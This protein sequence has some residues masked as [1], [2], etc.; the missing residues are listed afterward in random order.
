MLGSVVPEPC[1]VVL[2]DGRTLCLR[3]VTPADASAILALYAR[4]SSNSLYNRFG[5]PH[6]PEL[7]ET[8]ALCHI[9]PQ[10]GF[11]L[12]AEHGPRL[13]GVAHYV[14]TSPG[15]A[16]VAFVVDDD[17]HGLGVATSL[18]E[19]LAEI[20][21][22]QHLE[23]FEAYVLRGNTDMLRVF[24]D[25]GFEVRTDD[26]HEYEH[27]TLALSPT[28]R[29][30]D[31]TA[32]RAET[33]AS[34]S[35]RPFFEPGSVAVVGASRR[36]GQIGSEIFH[37][38]A[39]GG[40]TGR[41]VPVNPQAGEI[42]SVPCY[43]RV[44][45]IPG[46]I[47]LAVVAVPAAAVEAVVD[48]CIAKGVRAIVVISAG[49]GEIGGEGRAR[50]AAL[51]EK[52]RNAGIRM[53]GPNC[54]G[55]LNTDPA[56]HLNATFSPVF[57][58]SG[59]IAFSS[60]SG[61]L[62]LAILDFAARLNL[63]VSS[64]VSVGN[65]ADVSSNDLLQYW[66]EDPRTSVILLYLE[67][68][69]NPRTFSRLARRIGR[70]KPIVA[71]KAGRSLSGARAASSHTGALAAS[72]VV[73]DALF[74]EAGVIRTTTLEELFDVAVLLANQPV[75]RGNRVAILTNAGGPGILAAD[76][77]EALNMTVPRLAPSTVAALRAFLPAAA[78]IGNPVDMLATASAD[79]Y[80]RAIPLLLADPDVD[81]LLTIFIPPLVT[82]PEDVAK[83]IVDSVRRSDKPVITTFL[84]AQ[85]A[86]ASLDPVPCYAFPESAL[87]ALAH[88]ATY[89]K[90]RS[91]PAGSTRTFVDARRDTARDIVDR[92]VA[93]G[94]GWLSP[95]DGV[96]LLS[97]FNIPA[98]PTF[99]AAT[100]NEAVVM[101]TVAGYPCVMKAVGPGILH[102]SE[103]HA[104]VLDIADEA[105]ARAA[106]IDLSS[107]LGDAMTGVVVQPMVQD[108][109]EMFVGVT[110]DATFG[111]VIV[112][113]TGG[114]LVELL[115]DSVCR[116]HPLT[117]E[118]A[119]E[120][121]DTV[122][123]IVLLRGFRGSP[124]CKEEALHD[125]LLRV[126]ALVDC[127][128]E[129]VELDLNPVMVTPSGAQVADARIRVER[130][131]VPAPSRRIRY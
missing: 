26:A 24:K 38:L 114:T 52:V 61:A 60:Q 86:P 125:M 35:M 96:A 66:S 53:I 70:R 91:A 50:E 11:A 106:Y 44:S 57:P 127:C 46:E 71:V 88:A 20:A 48:D 94:G 120:M 119:R 76:A 5:A 63:G 41:V 93:S 110:L 6:R 83:A 13:V 74:R 99:S 39:A 42:A 34:A 1:D 77:A 10:D 40:F 23:T 116:L 72:D 47:D 18:L 98:A 87:R 128:P 102:K 31:R 129:I 78:S 103:L 28:D 68:F 126:S 19:R 113:G 130:G 32:A 100:P 59:R 84:G 22:R 105:A 27:V 17:M 45:A 80:R 82:D 3:A 107:R 30:L 64:F 37:N 69:G 55:V 89:G 43:P 109:V 111:H 81:A 67:S 12:A 90:W 118:S 9:A 123:G 85:G 124:R 58:P 8:T 112:C 15:C 108:A 122:R 73:V 97:A 79:D 121:L 117:D 16:E 2:R 29:L 101:G 75:P 25:A 7:A 65:K 131:S 92:A 36:R 62:G 51:L 115:R 33:A 56:F 54:M 14:M 4:L 95:L 104:V 49:F 21:R